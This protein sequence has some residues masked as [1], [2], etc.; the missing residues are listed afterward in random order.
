MLKVITVY[1]CIQDTHKTNT[2]D[3]NEPNTTLVQTGLPAQEK[4]DM[5]NAYLLG[6]IDKHR[7]FVRNSFEVHDLHTA[8]EKGRA[9]IVEVLDLYLT[10]IISAAEGSEYGITISNKDEWNTRSCL[11]CT[12]EYDLDGFQALSMADAIDELK[13]FRE[14]IIWLRRESSNLKS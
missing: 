7:F 3:M 5:L 13:E 9:E 14:E 12:D 8:L 1:S 10:D 11:W 4:L 2:M 6:Q